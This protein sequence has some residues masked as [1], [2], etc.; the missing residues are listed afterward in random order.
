M[1]K[2]ATRLKD[3]FGKDLQD[4]EDAVVT[5]DDYMPGFRQAYTWD[6][7]ANGY[8]VLDGGD[9]MEIGQ[10]IWVFFPDDTTLAP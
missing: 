5:A 1:T 7:I 2:T 10:G 9:P 3:N 8:R 6:A 4:S